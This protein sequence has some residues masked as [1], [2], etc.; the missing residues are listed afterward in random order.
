M[1]V[2]SRPPFCAA[3]FSDRAARANVVTPL[4]ALIIIAS[5]MEAQDREGKKFSKFND[6]SKKEIYSGEKGSAAAA[7]LNNFRTLEDASDAGKTLCACWL[8][9][10]SCSYA[11][12]IASLILHSSTTSCLCRAF[13]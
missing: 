3:P 5:G 8:P 2:T 9:V 11:I 4:Y 12:L 6:E 7:G 1:E 13:F 10:E